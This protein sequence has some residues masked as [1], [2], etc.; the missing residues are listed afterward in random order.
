MRQRP[1]LQIPSHRVPFPVRRVPPHEQS[2]Q[3]PRKRFHRP[4]ESKLEGTIRITHSDLLQVPGPEPQPGL[5]ASSYRS[6]T[7][8]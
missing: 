7:Q 1:D 4:C 6:D 5:P 2:Q 8:S 3:G